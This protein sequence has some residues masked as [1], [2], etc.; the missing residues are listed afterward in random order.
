M[1]G[2]WR[3]GYQAR[4]IGDYFCIACGEN[5]LQESGCRCARFDREH[6]AAV[7]RQRELDEI[8]ASSQGLTFYPKD[9]AEWRLEFERTGIA[10]AYER[11]TECY[12]GAKS[13]LRWA[14]N[15]AWEA[16]RSVP[17]SR[18]PG[19]RFRYTSGLILFGVPALVFLVLLLV[20]LV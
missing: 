11:M 20:G 17:A 12:E 6:R 1:Q 10:W 7:Q 14:D 16:S 9:Y 5:L 4:S 3:S 18:D 8:Y 2:Y 19:T 15:L 13:D